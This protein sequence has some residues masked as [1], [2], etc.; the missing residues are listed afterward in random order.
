[1]RVIVA[2]EYSGRVSRAFR[3]KGH[4]VYSCDLL[5]SDDNEYYHYHYQGDVP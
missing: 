4:K 1:M 2:C 3:D 5:P